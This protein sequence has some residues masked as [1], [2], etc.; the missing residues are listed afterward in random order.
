MIL[1][2]LFAAY[3][4]LWKFIFAGQ[5]LVMA[6]NKIHHFFVV[7]KFNMKLSHHDL[8][9]VI[10]GNTW[11]SAFPLSTW[12]CCDVESTSMT[13]IQRR[14]NVVCPVGYRRLISIPREKYLFTKPIIIS[15]QSHKTALVFEIM[16]PRKHKALNQ[17]CFNV[18]WD[19]QRIT[20]KG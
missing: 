10:F 16:H 7:N 15:Q 14:N 18:D 9:I 1:Y 4:K 5:V 11:N 8:N 19:F 3:N 12:R 13:L 2:S 17:W 6:Y 20:A